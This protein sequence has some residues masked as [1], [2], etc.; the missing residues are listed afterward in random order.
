MAAAATTVLLVVILTLSAA[1]AHCVLILGPGC[2]VRA[3]H[4]QLFFLLPEI[5]RRSA[6]NRVSIRDIVEI[7]SGTGAAHWPL[8][9]MRA[10][11]APRR[12]LHGA[13]RHRLTV[14]V[15]PRQPPLLRAGACR[16]RHVHLFVVLVTTC[17]LRVEQLSPEVVP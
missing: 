13:S 11:S 3:T 9:G 6:G 14:R 12:T 8:P 4:A 2:Q 1:E 10:P 16:T 5:P 15:L 17:A 7:C